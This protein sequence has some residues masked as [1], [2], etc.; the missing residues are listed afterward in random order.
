MV[1]LV[2]ASACTSHRPN[3]DQNL[4]VLTYNIHAGK[5]AAQQHNLQRVAEVIRSTGADIVLLQEV[6]RRTQRSAG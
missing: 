2:L 4:R 1:F 5:D 6:D 3:A